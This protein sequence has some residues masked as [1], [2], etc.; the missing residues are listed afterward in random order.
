MNKLLLL[1]LA[2]TSFSINCME[3]QSNKS[4]INNGVN[5]ANLNQQLFE[6]IRYNQINQVR[7]LIK[8]G[9][10]INI[11]HT[12][13]WTALELAIFE[14]K[15]DIVEL[16]ISYGV[17][18]NNI[19]HANTPLYRAIKEMHEDIAL[20]LINSGADIRTQS[21]L[22]ST[23]LHAAAWSGLKNLAAVLIKL[24][25]DINAKESK[26]GS[27]LHTPAFYGNKDIV[28]LLIENGADKNIEN[29]NCRKPAETTG[30]Q[31][32][33]ETINNYVPIVRR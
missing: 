10:D 12:S 3:I 18:V 30:N 11:I 20:L 19:T 16:L 14:G 22:G 13:G 7:E 4:Q 33:I 8:N 27:P 31:E 6:A 29:Y 15:K 32:I 25:A 17:N 24:G 28:E 26:D 2:I 21:Y 5:Q 23:A 1:T 9:A